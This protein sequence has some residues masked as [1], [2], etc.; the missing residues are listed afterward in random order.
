MV[1]PDVIGSYRISHLQAQTGLGVYAGEQ[2]MN[3]LIRVVGFNAQIRS[4]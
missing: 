1:S 4:P 3:F 2:V